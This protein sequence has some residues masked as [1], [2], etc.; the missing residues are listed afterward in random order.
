MIE[1]LKAALGGY[2]RWL[3]KP[4]IFQTPQ[5]P[6]ASCS[7]PLLLLVSHITRPAPPT[8]FTS[9]FPNCPHSKSSTS[10]ISLLPLSVLSNLNF[11]HRRTHCLLYTSST[12]HTL[13]GS[14]SSLIFPHCTFFTLCS[15]EYTSSPWA[16]VYTLFHIVYALCQFAL[17]HP[18]LHT[19][20]FHASHI[21]NFLYPL[22]VCPHS[23]L[24][25]PRF[26]PFPLITGVCVLGGGGRGFKL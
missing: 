22:V 3:S 21:P 6:Q 18:K 14:F 15:Y 11:S 9:F 26:P 25:I 24:Y 20:I 4:H 5:S 16:P 2:P 10:L 13:H 1:P 19:F 7:S 12:P 8:S 17:C 23:T